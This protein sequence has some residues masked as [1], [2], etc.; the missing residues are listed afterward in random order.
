M[1]LTDAVLAREVRHKSTQ[2]V[3]SFNG[4]QEQVKLTHRERRQ[5]VV[6]LGEGLTW[7]GRREPLGVLEICIFSSEWWLHRCKHM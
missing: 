4:D 2:G 7:R 1:G 5:I 3:V 6:A